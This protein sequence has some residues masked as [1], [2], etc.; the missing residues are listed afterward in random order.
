MLDDS[1]LAEAIGQG[2]HNFRNYSNTYYGPISL[3]EA[4]GNSLNIP[5]ILTIRHV[6][7][8]EYLSLLQRLGF[9]S[10]TQSTEV[11]DEGLALGNGEVTLLEIAQAYAALANR[12]MYKPLQVL[13]QP[14]GDLRAVRVYSE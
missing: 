13:M 3:R 10:L 8:G 5:T 9:Q 1:P 12:G 4:L 2:L 7:P 6:G 14:D 11:Y